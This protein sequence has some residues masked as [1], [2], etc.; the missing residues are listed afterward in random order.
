MDQ[1][2][3]AGEAT[4]SRGA[5]DLCRCRASGPAPPA[6]QSFTRQTPPVSPTKDFWLEIAVYEN[7]LS[8]RFGPGPRTLRQRGLPRVTGQPGS[9]AQLARFGPFGS[10]QGH[11]GPSRPTGGLL[12]PVRVLPG[13][14]E[15][16]RSGPSPSS[17]SSLRKS[18]G[19]SPGSTPR[20]C[21]LGPFL[22]IPT[23]IGNVFT[24]FHTIPQ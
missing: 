20:K 21:G 22:R 17:D 15:S 6:V 19:P 7:L 5:S 8:P 23:L 11:R 18:L 24:L 16:V 9:G 10:F 14:F 4:L 13:G 3:A 2:D 1:K 12:S